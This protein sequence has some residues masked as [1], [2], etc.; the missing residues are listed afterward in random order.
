MKLKR[1]MSYSYCRFYIQK[2]LFSPHG[3]LVKKRF[4]YISIFVEEEDDVDEDEERI[5]NLG[6]AD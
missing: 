6:R 2:N 3:N 1:S 5:E 4:E